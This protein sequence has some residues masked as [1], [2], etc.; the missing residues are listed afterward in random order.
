MNK[1]IEAIVR[2][3]LAPPSERYLRT[4]ERG[5]ALKFAADLRDACPR[6]GTR[7]F[8]GYTGRRRQRTPGFVVTLADDREAALAAGVGR[9][10]AEMKPEAE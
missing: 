8:L 4:P 9:M 3:R 6:I 2:L 7:V 10:I 1:L 5:D